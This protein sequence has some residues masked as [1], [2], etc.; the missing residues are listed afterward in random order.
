MSSSK[1]RLSFSTILALIPW[2]SAPV[3]LAA[4]NGPT[5][6]QL[7]RASYVT[8]AVADH[9]YKGH[10]VHAM[11]DIEAACDILG[12]D[13]RGDGKGKEKQNVSDDQLR[14]AQRML[15]D[16]YQL[17]SIANQS[18]VVPHID[19]AIKQLSMALNVN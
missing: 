7:L 16:A 19:T 11:H 10:R 15:Q 8:L 14:A 6:M 13:I 12:T 3:A 4:N 9:D 2:V 18:Q 5:E 17:A 1:F